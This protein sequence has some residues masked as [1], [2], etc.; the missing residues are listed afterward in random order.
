MGF[1]GLVSNGEKLKDTYLQCFFA[2]SHVYRLLCTVLLVNKWLVTMP[3]RSKRHRHAIA[4]SDKS[5]NDRILKKTSTKLP[6]EAVPGHSL[7]CNQEK[8]EKDI[9]SSSHNLSA[10]PVPLV[11][12]ANDQYSSKSHV[13]RCENCKRCDVDPYGIVMENLTIQPRAKCQLSF[14]KS[15]CSM[16]D[17][18]PGRVDVQ[19]CNE[20][21]NTLLDTKEKSARYNWS[22]CWPSFL[23]KMLANPL[24][25]DRL[26]EMWQYLPFSMRAS[27]LESFR[28]LGEDYQVVSLYE[29][30][31][32]F[33]DITSYVDEIERLTSSGLLVDLMK[34]CNSNHYCS[35][36]CPW[37]CTEFPDE[38]GY[39]SFARLLYAKGFQMPLSESFVSR[40]GTPQGNLSKCFVG[41]REDYLS[42]PNYFLNFVDHPIRPCIRFLAGKGPMICTCKEHDGGSSKQYLHPP[43]NPVTGSIP[44]TSGDQLA[45]AVVAPRMIK[46]MKKNKHSDSY[47]MQR[48][49]GGFRGTD[50]CNIMDPHRFDRNSCL[51]DANT[52]LALFGR[53]DIRSKLSQ[54]VREQI[55]PQCYEADFL[56]LTY[57]MDY[58][59]RDTF[60]SECRAGSNFVPLEESMKMMMH[61][62]KCS[63][64]PFAPSWPLALLTCRP[65]ISKYGQKPREVAPFRVKHDLRLPWFLLT[66]AT[67]I[68]RLW[69]CIVD[70]VPRDGSLSW[71]GWLLSFAAKNV[72]EGSPSRS[73]SRST[74]PYKGILTPLQLAWKLQSQLDKEPTPP[75]EFSPVFNMS[76]VQDC[77]EDTRNV[78]CFRSSD[79]FSEARKNCTI[80]PSTEVIV[81]TC[82]SEDDAN[83]PPWFIVSFVIVLLKTTFVGFFV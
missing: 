70:S 80:A 42:P 6:E 82:C 28:A 52:T 36:R 59:S 71:H 46:S 47:Q 66:M 18:V 19:V 9:I 72:L 27:W 45:H 25:S 7:V 35:V 30:P 13:R 33:D 22:D 23:W 21:Y 44:C 2:P 79:A 41:M 48:C 57:S 56:E 31:S 64:F 20:C 63:K 43:V 12:E 37:G 58:P 49:C 15:L 54:L 60:L 39:V 11:I 83:L 69:E 73:G 4:I 5:R 38:C 1:Q 68:P 62:E 76:Q 32:F 17:N 78:A 34:G 53:P 50:S 67:N 61:A 65:S 10:I 16:K 3:K 40:W 81:R 51:S 77:L 74:N 8:P 55:I 75:K 24:N 29:P 14:K 26:M